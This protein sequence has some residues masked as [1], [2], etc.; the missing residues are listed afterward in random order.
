MP[1]LGGGTRANQGRMLANFITAP[2]GSLDERFTGDLRSPDLSFPN[3][4]M[5]V[6]DVRDRN[7]V[8]LRAGAP[9][10]VLSLTGRPIWAPPSLNC[11]FMARFCLSAALFLGSS[12]ADLAGIFWRRFGGVGHIQRAHRCCAFGLVYP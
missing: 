3:D 11:S 2:P 4:R 12:L 8:R 9:Q 6:P 5:G 1:V 10:R 7:I